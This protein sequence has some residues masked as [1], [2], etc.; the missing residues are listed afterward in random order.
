MTQPP[1]EPTPDD[2][3]HPPGPPPPP[4]PGQYPGYGPPY[5]RPPPGQ[6][7]YGGDTSSYYQPIDSGGMSSTAKVVLGVVIGVFTGFFLW[8]CAAIV[9]SA[10]VSDSDTDFLFFAAVAPLI[11]PAPLLIWKATRPWAVGLLMGTAISSIGM[12]GLCAS[13]ISSF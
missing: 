2:A 6:N 4:P 5:D 1:D 13:L 12:S 11:V 9:F 10:S 7:P 8:S 3:W